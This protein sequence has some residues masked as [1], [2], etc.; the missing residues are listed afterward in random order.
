ME[1]KLSLPE[2]SVLHFLDDVGYT[3]PILLQIRFQVSMGRIQGILD[4]LW[5]MGLI[6]RP[7]K[8]LVISKSFLMQFPEHKSKIENS[9][10]KILVI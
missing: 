8:G 7:V 5:K 2:E 6:L 9:L 4:I 10:G 3:A 1:S